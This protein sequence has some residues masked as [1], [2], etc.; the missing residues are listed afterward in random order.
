[1]LSKEL[2]MMLTP[3]SGSGRKK[4]DLQTNPTNSI[5]FM[6]ELKETK[7]AAITFQTEWVYKV[8]RE[9]QKED[10]IPAFCLDF[11]G[12]KIY[13][14][15]LYDWQHMTSKSKPESSRALNGLTTT[16]YATELQEGLELKIPNGHYAPLVVTSAFDFK[17]Y[18]NKLEQGGFL[19]GLA[20]PVEVIGEQEY[21]EE[22][23]ESPIEGGSEITPD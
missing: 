10:K 7:Y 2:D 6:V 23:V 16:L 19:D 5:G 1:M 18:K 14:I 9:A 17:N 4:G 8:Y 3:G 15:T 13:L 21:R 20:E 11:N 12:R 22:N